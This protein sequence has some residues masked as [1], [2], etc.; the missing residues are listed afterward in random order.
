MIGLSWFQRTYHANLRLHSLK[1][2]NFKSLCQNQN[3]L[4]F[5][6]HDQSVKSSPIRGRPFF[7]RMT[8]QFILSVSD[9]KRNEE[10]PMFARLRGE[11]LCESRLKEATARSVCIVSIPRRSKSCIMDSVGRD[12]ISSYFSDKLFGQVPTFY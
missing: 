2:Y 7:E 4:C 8:S 5:N 6:I 11:P 9:M 12:S 10:S 1:N 3:V